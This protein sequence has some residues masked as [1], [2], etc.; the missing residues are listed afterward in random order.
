VP[1]R[2][3]LGLLVL[4][5]GTPGLSILFGTIWALV[6]VVIIQGNTTGTNIMKGVFIQV[7]Q[8]MEDAARVSGAGWIR[9]YFFIW[10]P[11]MMK[12]LNPYI[13]VLKPISP[14]AWMPLALFVIKDSVWSSVEGRVF[15]GAG[16]PP[17]C[18]LRCSVGESSGSGCSR[19]RPA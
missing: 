1:G 18:P 19:A 9:T 15:G 7:G 12:T 5:L 2:P 4:F 3:G 16:V 11:L 6:L 14:L 17:R 10:I 13:Q 8:D